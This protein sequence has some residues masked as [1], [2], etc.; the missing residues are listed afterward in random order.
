MRSFRG[1]HNFWIFV[2][3]KKGIT[4]VSFRAWA[5]RVVVYN[6]HSALATGSWTGIKA[7]QGSP[8]YSGMH[9]QDPASLFLVHTALDPHGD[10][11]HGSIGST[12]GG[13]KDVKFKK[14]FA[15][16]IILTCC[17]QITPSERISLISRITLTI[18]IMIVH[19]TSC[20]G[21]T[22]TRAR[23]FTFVSNTCQVDRAL[24]VYSTFWF[25]L[26]IRI[27]F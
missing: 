10:G 13:T 15:L 17:F 12:F 14:A 26:N 11:L 2:A 22:N 18:W 7:T 25:A 20:V 1:C 19:W 4:T 16:K 5:N 9:W 3:I 23:I 24:L 6:F 27:P 21:S 8:K